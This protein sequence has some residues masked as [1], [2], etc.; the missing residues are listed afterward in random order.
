M[1]ANGLESRT[2]GIDRL[3]WMRIVFGVAFS[4]LAVA[5]WLL[6]V[7][8]HA[9]FEE[10]AAS[11]HTRTIPLRAPRG[12]IFDRDGRILVDNRESFTIAIVREHAVHL[13]QTIS[14]LAEVTGVP[15]Q[16]I[17]DAMQRQK[18][19]PL[20]R[21]LPVID[22]ATFA[23][24]A[25][26]TARRLELPE[27]VVQPVPVRTYPADRMAAHLF[28]YVGEVHESQL[29][30]P[31]YSNLKAG[32]IVGQTGLEKIYNQVL[33]GVD[34]NRYIVVNSVGREIEQT[35]EDQPTVGKRVQLSVDLDVQRALSDGFQLS[36]FAGAGVV[37]DPRTGEILALTSQPEFD[38]NDFAG[39]IDSAKWAQLST[40]P[41]KPLPNRLLQGRYSPG[42]TFKILMATAA[43]SEGLITPDFQVYCPGSFTIYGHR[44]NCDK[45]EGHGSL[46]LSHALE[47]SCDVYFYKLASMM[48]IDTIHDYAEK[49]GLVGKT[50]I[51]L[52]N[53]VESLVPSTAWKLRTSG[54]PWYPGETISVGI[55][56]G[57]VSV[58]PIALATMIASI[59]NGGTV[60]TPHLLKAI[61]DGRGWTPVPL[62]PPRSILP[63][64]P[65]VLEP[66]RQ[67]LW[68]AVNGAGTAG[69]ARID[70]RDVVGKTGTAQVVSLQNVKAAAAAGID[71]R[72]HSW[73]VFYAPKD[74]PEVAGVVFV[75]HGGWGATAATPI[76]RYVLETYFAKKDK[77]PL[78]T[79]K[80]GGDGV[81]TVVP[82]PAP[83]TASPVPSAIPAT[84]PTAATPG[85]PNTAPSVARATAASPATSSAHLSD[86]AMPSAGT[87]Q[88]RV[89]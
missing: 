24:V 29:S 85:L 57:P 76:A 77:R 9:K 51:D 7:V 53:E 82:A 44:F 32:A 47:Q 72:D 4:V 34:G 6:Q 60:V 22:R 81:L 33:M 37:L 83:P 20:F 87:G 12:L 59:A 62:A 17:D 61:D 13:D 86:Q 40:D 49:L 67:G 31:E 71:H 38:P 18:K 41:L 68:L 88:Q 54:E 21:P 73:F 2:R 89:P 36:N 10:L 79:A 35:Q 84:T 48:K 27:V 45:H 19:E 42:S 56:Q 39:G 78:P 66:V 70:G 75:E 30:T 25:A 26:V 3:G 11:N 28:G 63:L 80:I 8:Q 16:S 43:L 58:T 50:G 52:P 69:R 23:Q 1:N 14:R 65:D 64:R 74:N 15:R 55:G 5:F 46:D